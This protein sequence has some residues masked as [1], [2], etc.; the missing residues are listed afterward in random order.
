MG[1]C[2]VPKFHLARPTCVPGGLYILAY[3]FFIEP[4]R[5]S[6]RPGYIFYLPFVSF[7]KLSKAISGST[8]PIFTIFSPNGRHLRE[9]CQ[10]GPDFPIPQGTLPWQQMLDKIGEMTSIQHPGILKLDCNIAIWISSFIALMIPLHRVQI[11]WTLV[12]NTRDWGARNCTFETIQQKAAYL[13]E[14]LNNYWTNLHQRSVL[15]EVCM[16]IRKLTEVLR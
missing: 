13:T 9:C 1:L 5:L 8:E 10:S 15:V 6:C 11:W 4:T 3:F 16:G 14:Y 2:L 7:F 12:Q